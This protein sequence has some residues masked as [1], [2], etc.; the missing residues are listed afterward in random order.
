[1]APFSLER[2][3]PSGSAPASP[4]SPQQNITVLFT[5]EAIQTHQ[6]GRYGTIAWSGFV[7]A[8][9]DDQVLVLASNLRTNRRAGAV[10]IFSIRT[11]VPAARRGLYNILAK[12]FGSENVTSVE[13]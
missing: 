5:P 13:E 3:T 2:C 1:M 6:D 7:N 8:K 12:Q 4:L 11:L 10:T 9:M